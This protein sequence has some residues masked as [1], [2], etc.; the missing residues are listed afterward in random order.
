MA[1]E[2][3]GGWLDGRLIR[4]ARKEQQCVNS[5]AASRGNAPACTRRIKPG[6]HY[7][8]VE[9]DPDEAGGFGMKKACMACA[10]PEAREA[11]LSRV[12]R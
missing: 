6:D 10:G 1:V 2:I 7:A 9:C 4:R 8:E 5:Y 11:L 12:E 3:K